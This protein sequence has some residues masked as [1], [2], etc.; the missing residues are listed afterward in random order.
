VRLLIVEDNPIDAEL[1]VESLRADRLADGIHIARDGVEAL[2]FLL[3]RGAYAGRAGEPLPRLVTLDLKLPKVDGLEVLREIKS[4]IRTRQV[5]V[6]MLTSSKLERDVVRSYQLGVN[7]Y[8][9]KPVGV[10]SFRA[11]VRELGRYWLMLNQ[12]AL[13]DQT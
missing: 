5:P 1:I 3:C 13:E 8:V 11:A 6:V 7:S 9:Q 12:T 10:E 2:D 4:E